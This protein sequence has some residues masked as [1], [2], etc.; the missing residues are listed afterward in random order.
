MLGSVASGDAMPVVAGGINPITGPCSMRGGIGDTAGEGQIRGPM[1]F[2]AA[3]PKTKPPG[4]AAFRLFI[5]GWRARR[6]WDRKPI[7]S[8][9]IHTCAPA[10]DRRMLWPAQMNERSL[11]DHDLASVPVY[12][13][14]PTEAAESMLG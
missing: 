13:S 3:R 4:G 9:E 11:S 1:P 8:F 12:R 14:W 2:V 5:L 6:R 7:H 10:N